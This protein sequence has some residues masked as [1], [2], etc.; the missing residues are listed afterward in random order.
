MFYNLKRLVKTYFRDNLQTT[1]SQELTLPTRC[2]EKSLNHKWLSW[3]FRLSGGPQLLTE[4][5]F[6]TWDQKVRHLACARIP[7]IGFLQTHDATHTSITHARSST[8]VMYTS[9]LSSQNAKDPP[10]KMCCCL[11]FNQNEMIHFEALT[12]TSDCTLIYCWLYASYFD[13]KYINQ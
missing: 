5:R 7:W 3:G 8:V 11:L 1:P 12:G 9:C 2:H 4:Y 6:K 13:Y 10:P